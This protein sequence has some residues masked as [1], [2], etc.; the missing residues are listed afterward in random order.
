MNYKDA[1]G[2]EPTGSAELHVGRNEGVT[3]GGDVIFPAQLRIDGK[4]VREGKVLYFRNNLISEL[5]FEKA[6]A[7]GYAKVN[8]A[9]LSRDGKWLFVKGKNTIDTEGVG[10]K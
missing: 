4:A 3:A 2:A 7:D 1:F 9:G 10:V 8:N 6:G 5:D